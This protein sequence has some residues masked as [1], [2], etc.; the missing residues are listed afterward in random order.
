[1]IQH[2]KSSFLDD[3]QISLFKRYMINENETVDFTRPIWYYFQ[4]MVEAFG[5][6]SVDVI[7]LQ[8]NG[9]SINEILRDCFRHSC[10]KYIEYDIESGL[11]A[12]EFF[13]SQH[14]GYIIY[15]GKTFDIIR[16]TSEKPIFQN[17]FK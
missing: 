14:I 4:N 11:F 17:V 13:D 6:N 5:E 12:I 16:A 8:Y 3:N 9:N 7:C 1:M 2:E 10:V 15:D